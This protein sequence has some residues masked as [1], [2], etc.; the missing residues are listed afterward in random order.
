MTEKEKMLA[1]QWYDANNDMALEDERKDCKKL[2]QAYNQL[3]CEQEQKRY[4]LLCRILGGVGK[5]CTIQPSFYCDYGYNINVGENFY[6]NHNSVFLDA[7]KITFGDNV[8]IGPNCGFYTAEHPLEVNVR[9]RGL[10]RAREIKVGN[11]VWIGGNV[12]VLAGVTIGNNC[13]LGAGSVV[14]KNI[15]DNALACG[16]P[17]RVVR[18][19]EN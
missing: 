11:N 2:C 6:A 7:A 3:S 19:L 18:L 4:E 17:A 8:F 9:N 16:N 1:E 14:T 13:V 5:N 15:P 10:E 12:C